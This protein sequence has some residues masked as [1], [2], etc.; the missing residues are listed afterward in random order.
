MNAKGKEIWLD[1][2]NGYH[3]HIHCLVSLGTTQT[4]SDVAR[5][6]KGES[7]FCINNEKLTKVKFKWQDDF[8]AVGV[9]ESHVA[10][11]RKYILSQEEK[12]SHV[13]F[14]EEIDVFMK[15]YGWKIIKG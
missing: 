9:S 7:S 11:V 2:V 10:E 1:C 6:I 15:K 4:L 5:L 8:W 14:S 13:T 12:H 3:D